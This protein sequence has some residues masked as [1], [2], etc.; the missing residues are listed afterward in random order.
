[1]VRKALVSVLGILALAGLTC[2]AMH[3]YEHRNDA[4]E[5]VTWQELDSGKFQKEGYGLTV[6]KGTKVEKF[7]VTYDGIVPHFLY[8]KGKVILVRMGKPL[9]GSSVLAGMSG[10]PTHFRKKHKLKVFDWLCPKWKLAGA[11]AFGFMSPTAGPS[12]GGITPIQYMLSQKKYTG[13]VSLKQNS[14]QKSLEVLFRPIEINQGGYKI[15]LLQPAFT[16]ISEPTNVSASER[17][18]IVAP[19]PGEAVT[20]L[21]TD[22]DYKV[23]GT[24][25]VTYVTKD[26]FWLCGHPISMEGKLI[27]PAYKASVATSYKS[28]EYA[29]KMVADQHEPV[30]YVSYDSAFA[31]E[32]EIKPLPKNAM[33]P[34]KIKLRVKGKKPVEINYKVLRNKS[35]TEMLIANVGG[36]AL[37]SL[38]N[39]KEKMTAESSAVVKF[40]NQSI[41][42][43]DVS[44]SGEMM[45]FGP[46]ILK[47]NPW[48]II[49]KSAS[50]VGK[51]MESEW[52][53]KVKSVEAEIKL[54]PGYKILYLDSYKLVNKKNE[55]ITKA[56]LG[57][58][59]S[60]LLGIKNKNGSKKFFRKMS[61]RMPEK[62]TLP[63]GKEMF[64]EI[65]MSLLIQSGN[66]FEEENENKVLNRSPENKKEV[67]AELMINQK[68]FHNLYIQLVIPDLASKESGSELSRK[69]YSPGWNRVHKLD[70]LRS[71]KPSKKKV[72][73]KK[74]RSPPK[75]YT[76]DIKERIELQLV[77]PQNI[78][79]PFTAYPTM[80][81][82]ST[83][84]VVT[85]TDTVTAS[86]DTLKNSDQ[87]K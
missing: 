76:L 12:L 51:L 36:M 2:W 50:L 11:I 78:T 7:Y 60:L 9:E 25:T 48:L 85:S 8:P 38:W 70:F 24:C 20:M 1:M 21:L 54:S 39:S 82:A 74:I 37:E 45:Q 42:L 40:D 69:K 34:V 27:A 65:P 87:V 84:T 46:F 86:T 13:L 22:G 53:F 63:K 43:Y 41:K 10:S 19:K 33:V 17:N 66:R 28:P 75:Y 5:F 3:N 56:N 31:V 71:L 44:V 83:T 72:F 81:T 6:F 55:L 73:L 35:F 58:E 59:V 47:S 15:K 67:L 57:E 4:S 61:L 77:I 14:K 16:V 79:P 18:K 26:R 64:H 32:G 23:G 49:N 52:K 62:I 29:F 80:V 30:G 68:N